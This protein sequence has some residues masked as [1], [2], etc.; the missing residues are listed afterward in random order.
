LWKYVLYDM[1]ILANTVELCVMCESV[2]LQL[3]II[4]SQLADL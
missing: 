3:E 1:F 4:R 2:G